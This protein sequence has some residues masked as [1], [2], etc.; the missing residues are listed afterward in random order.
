MTFSKKALIGVVFCLIISVNTGC[1]DYLG[2]IGRSL[3]LLS[4]APL[5]EDGAGNEN[6]SLHQVKLF[7][8]GDQQLKA[9]EAAGYMIAAGAENDVEVVKESEDQT[10]ITV[11]YPTVTKR[12]LK[13]VVGGYGR[14]TCFPPIVQ[15]PSDSDTSDSDTSD[16]DEENPMKREFYEEDGNSIFG[17]T[18]NGAEHFQAGP[19]HETM[20]E[21]PMVTLAKKRCTKVREKGYM[22]D[23]PKMQMPLFGSK[24][25]F[26]GL[27]RKPQDK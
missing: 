9:G 14:Y 5:Q 8:V 22:K 20:A 21:V 27:E 26:G 25:P 11:D 17:F 10:V 4:T 7:L 6:D 15:S 12:F 13:K 16:S 3:G 24:P 23:H 2:Q 18:P 19:A 1:M